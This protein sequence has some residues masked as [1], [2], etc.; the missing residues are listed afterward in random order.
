MC[1][2]RYNSATTAIHMGAAQLLG[3]AAAPAMASQ[4]VSIGSAPAALMLAAALY[5][6]GGLAI[7]VTTLFTKWGCRA[8]RFRRRGNHGSVTSNL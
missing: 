8:L 1:S 3:A 2:A 7:I 5:S 4:A 6:L